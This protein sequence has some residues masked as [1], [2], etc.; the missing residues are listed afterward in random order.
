M[1][2]GIMRLPMCTRTLCKS[3]PI[4][5]Y[6]YWTL[7]ELAA[8]HHVLGLHHLKH[9]STSLQISSLLSYSKVVGMSLASFLYISCM[10]LCDWQNVYGCLGLGVGVDSDKSGC[11]PY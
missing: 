10:A 6:T 9:S 3:S 1:I 5:P 2:E 7:V 8:D 4:S 11:V